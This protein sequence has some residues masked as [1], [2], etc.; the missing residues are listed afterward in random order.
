MHY[1]ADLSHETH[2]FLQHLAA[3]DSLL[4]V[5]RKEQLDLRGDGS[6]IDSFLDVAEA[7]G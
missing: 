1:C 4:L 6:N 7:F 5:K 2:T 3:V